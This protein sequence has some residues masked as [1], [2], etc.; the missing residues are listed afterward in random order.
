LGT[1]VAV[2]TSSIVGRHPWVAA[3]MARRKTIS[4][5][6]PLRIGPLLSVSLTVVDL[7]LCYHKGARRQAHP[8][9][10]QGP[11]SGFQGALVSAG[12]LRW[13]D[14]DK[15]VP[16]SQGLDGLEYPTEAAARPRDI[17]S[18]VR[19]K[20]LGDRRAQSLRASWE[21]PS[22]AWHEARYDPSLPREA[23]KKRTSMIQS[24]YETGQASS[25]MYSRVLSQGQS[26]AS[27]QTRLSGRADSTS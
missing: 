24:P 10:S 23:S 26:R 1:G 5:Q 15:A 6:T 19:R 25:N 3:D 12:H 16:S 11:V 21:Q 2:V 4:I 9:S 20:A 13:P 22:A 27:W 7:V 18:Q 8:P 14:N 17:Q